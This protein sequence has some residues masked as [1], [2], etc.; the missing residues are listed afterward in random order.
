MDIHNSDS[1]MAPYSPFRNR[2]WQFHRFH[3][4]SARHVEACYGGPQPLSSLNGIFPPGSGHSASGISYVVTDITKADVKSGSIDHA[5]A[6]IA[7][8]CNVF[9]YPVNCTDCSI[10][11]GEPGEGQWSRSPS[12]L[13]IPSHLTPWPGWC[14]RR[15]KPTAWSPSTRAELSSRRRSSPRTGRPR[16]VPAPT[17]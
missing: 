12:N 10:D 16:E 2:V 13:V 9:V 7:P 14:S 4:V 15:S 6:V 8:A 3:Q 1:P 5:I 17:P 11:P